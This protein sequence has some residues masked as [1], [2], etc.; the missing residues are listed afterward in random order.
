VQEG[1]AAIGFPAVCA[2]AHLTV[3]A[4]FLGTTESAFCGVKI[5]EPL[6]QATEVERASRY[7]ECLSAVDGVPVK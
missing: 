2:V 1:A 5:T 7:P 3:Q 6:E 4:E